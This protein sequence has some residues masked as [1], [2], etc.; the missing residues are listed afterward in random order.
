MKNETIEQEIKRKNVP[1]EDMDPETK[2]EFMISAH[3]GEIWND[4]GN[5]NLDDDDMEMFNSIFDSVKASE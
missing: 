4:D 2:V 1:F 5:M 3:S